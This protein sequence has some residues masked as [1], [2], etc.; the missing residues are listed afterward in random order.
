MPRLKITVAYTGTAF[1]GWQLQALL[2]D[3][4]LRRPAQ[5]NEQRSVQGELEAVVS[6]LVNAPVRV[7]G[8]GRT[9]SGVHADGQVAHF[10]IPENKLTLDWQYALNRLLPD[11]ISVMQVEHVADSFHS[12]FD[13]S[14]KS[15]I[16]RLWL[17]R[18]FL[19]PTIRPF[20]WDIGPLDFMAMRE[21]AAHLLGE[22][23]FAAMQNHGMKLESTVRNVMLIQADPEEPSLL[24]SDC[25]ESFLNIQSYAGYLQSWHFKGDGFLKQMVRNM[26]GLL[27]H[28]GLGKTKPEEV[29]GI[30]ASC[31]RRMSGVTA[32]ARGLSLSRVY[33]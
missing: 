24:E 11:D 20:V 30:L 25:P 14:A 29:P 19:P 26:M 8:A 22:H 33:Y 4:E 3:V 21:A 9:D 17:T 2:P 27:C 7:H 18:R 28:V 23:D 31:D 13:A 5:R 15:Y 12:R 32:P 16:Y 1:C 6:R 10:D